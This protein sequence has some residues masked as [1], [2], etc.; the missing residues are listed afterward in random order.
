MHWLKRAATVV[1][2]AA[3]SPALAQ[4]ADFRVGD[5]SFTLPL[6]KGYCVPTRG[7]DVYR[8]N[9]A[10]SLDKQNVTALSI[11]PCAENADPLDYMLIKAPIAMVNADV[12]MPQLL[13]MLG[14]E[15][16]KPE[17]ADIPL[18]GTEK[19]V[20]DALTEHAGAPVEVSMA[21]G[22][23]GHD[24]RCAYIGGLARVEG[25]ADGGMAVG[26][27]V[28]VAGGRMLMVFVYSR[29]SDASA[30]RALLPRARALALSVKVKPGN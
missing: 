7:N 30:V 28:T 12:T 29:G 1:A 26:G 24:D 20:G 6:P 27:C 13:S 9:F 23:R 22:P 18:P 8:T 15:F 3:A 16:D 25:M 2:V 10:A 21:I 5:V 11:V 19:T 14:P 4:N 17:G